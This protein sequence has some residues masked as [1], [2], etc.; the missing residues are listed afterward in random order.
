VK[1][2]SPFQPAKSKCGAKASPL[3]S[4]RFLILST[5]F[6]GLR[7]GQPRTI[8]NARGQ[9]SDGVYSRLLSCLSLL[10][11]IHRDEAIS[12]GTTNERGLCGQVQGPPLLHEILS[13]KSLRQGFD[14]GSTER[15]GQN[16]TNPVKMQT[17][18]AKLIALHFKLSFHNS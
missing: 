13:T 5:K 11:P 6:L 17:D 10:V 8:S 4:K 15:S 1:S 9:C 16:G 2:L 7:S 18:R 12:A 14:V 3:V